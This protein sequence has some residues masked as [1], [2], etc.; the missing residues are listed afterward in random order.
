MSRVEIEMEV[1]TAAASPGVALHW[2]D[3]GGINFNT[4]RSLAS[5]GLGATRS[6]IATTRLGSFRQRVLRIISND[7]MTVY[8]VDADIQGGVS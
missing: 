8:G 7:A 3:D 6:R 1:G 4:P 2:S 5:G